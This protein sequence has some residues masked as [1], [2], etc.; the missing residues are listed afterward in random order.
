MIL[1]VTPSERASECAAALHSATGEEIVVAESLVRATTFLRVG[2]FLLVVLD[3]HLLET[4]ADEEATMLSQLG[5]ALLLQVNLAITGMDRLVREVRAALERR[6]RE[7]ATARQSVVGSLR[8]ELNNTLTALLLSVELA[9]QTPN[10]PDSA[11][12]KLRTM[13]EL[14]RTLRR[15]LETAIQP[16]SQPAPC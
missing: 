5:T 14:L 2:C 8:S 16:Q 4:S 12:E 15:Q 1:L 13:Q 11:T 7:E 10:L 9:L 6:Q 3:Q